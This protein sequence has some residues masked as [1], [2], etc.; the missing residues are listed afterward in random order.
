MDLIFT[1]SSFLKKTTPGKDE[2]HNLFLKHLGCGEVQILCNIFNTS[3][4]T[5]EIPMAWLESVIVPILKPGEDPAI[6]KS[7][8]PIALISCTAKLMER[9]IQRR[10]EWLIETSGILPNLLHGYRRSKGTQTALIVMH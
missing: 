8:R 10:L 2:I 6:P 4:A 5:A 7:Y 9:V 3:L 1:R